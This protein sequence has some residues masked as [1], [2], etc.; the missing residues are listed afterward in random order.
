LIV[1]GVG[2]LSRFPNDQLLQ[3]D[4]ASFVD[5]LDGGIGI[6]RRGA[7]DD[8]RTCGVDVVLVVVLDVEPV[9][10]IA[11]LLGNS[12]VSSVGVLG[13]I[14]GEP[15]CDGSVGDE[16]LTR[17]EM[18]TECG[19]ERDEPL[20][21]I[22]RTVVDSI[23]VL[24]ININTVEAILLNKTSNLS[25]EALGINTISGRGFG[26]AKD[27][28]HQANSIIVQ[29]LDDALSLGLRE[30]SEGLDLVGGAGREVEGEDEDVETVK[31]GGRG[32]DGA[33]R[34]GLIGVDD[35]AGR[36]CKESAGGVGRF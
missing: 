22:A 13:S 1:I 10:V 20:F 11:C 28:H 5:L 36:G 6:R 25:S 16:V 33:V 2:S 24:I 3:I 14:G 12:A 17:G 29:I 35:P 31:F 7:S 19:G 9:D 15:W 26:G 18:G 32:H 30:R 23:K 27:G 34:E 4:T 21:S 8:V